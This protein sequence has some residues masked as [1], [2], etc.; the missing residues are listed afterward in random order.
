[1]AVAPGSWMTPGA[2]SASGR[3]SASIAFALGYRLRGSLAIDLASTAFSRLL[4]SSRPGSCGTGAVTCAI[5]TCASVPAY[6]AVPVSACHS[7]HPTAYTSLAGVA[8][9]PSCRS[10]AM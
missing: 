9:C 1:M 7:R 5:V 6:G 2:P 8:S 4:K 3:S 10:G